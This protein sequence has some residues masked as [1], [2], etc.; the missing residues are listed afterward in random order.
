MSCGNLAFHSPHSSPAVSSKAHCTLPDSAHLPLWSRK[1]VFISCAVRLR[2]SLMA[3]IRIAAPLGPYASYNN[4]SNF[5]AGSAARLIARSIVS[6][7]TPA[8]RAF[9]TAVRKRGLKSGFGSVCAAAEISLSDLENIFARFL[10]VIS[11]LC[12]IPDQCEC[13]DIVALYRLARAKKSRRRKDVVL[14]FRPS[15]LGYRR[16]APESIFYRVVCSGEPLRVG[17]PRQ[18]LVEGVAAEERVHV[19]PYRVAHIRVEVVG[20]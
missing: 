19:L 17:S 6:A 4:S 11:F 10:S 3:V 1:T 13:P 18:K 12:F 9:A 15:G 14:S 5:S 8:S 20:R 7:G 2:L 16:L